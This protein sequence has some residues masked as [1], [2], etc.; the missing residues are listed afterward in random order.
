M[1][2]HGKRKLRGFK[3]NAPRG[4]IRLRKGQ[5]MVK[6][7]AEQPSS[8]AAGALKW[9]IKAEIDGHLRLR[10]SLTVKNNLVVKSSALLTNYIFFN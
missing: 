1:E 5:G 9:S 3:P 10:L 7:A 6:I 2:L 8:H 4:Q